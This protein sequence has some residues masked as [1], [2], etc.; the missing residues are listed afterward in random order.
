[1]ERYVSS[2]IKQGNRFRKPTEAFFITARAE[3]ERMWG[4]R[5]EGA[6]L[7]VA[8]FFD[9]VKTTMLQR[10]QREIVKRSN[11]FISAKNL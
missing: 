9:R 4:V 7:S 2:V 5:E 11:E 6:S 3:F 1:M 8:S 10:W